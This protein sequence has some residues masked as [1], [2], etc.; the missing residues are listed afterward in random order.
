MENERRLTLDAGLEYRSAEGE[1]PGLVGYAIVYNVLSDDL[2]GFR[3][4]IAPG[5]FDGAIDSNPDVRALINHNPTLVL[6]RTTA[7]TLKLVKD[8]RGVKVHIDPPDTS[9]ARDLQ[10]SVARRDVSQMS[11]GFRVEKDVWGEEII[12]GRRTVV[13]TVQTARS[14]FDVSV[15][16][17]PAYPD[18]SV[19]V[20]GLQ[21]W[22]ST[23]DT[24]REDLER[25]IRQMELEGR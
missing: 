9:Y 23:R 21:D 24:H 14:L 1:K 10:V 19:A 5:A 18:S 25:L 8:E 2:G 11:F 12:D 22:L 6:G 13:R 16:T 15:V 20:R 7:G 3:E 17:Y 4:R